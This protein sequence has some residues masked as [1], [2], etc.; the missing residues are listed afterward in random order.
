MVILLEP[1]GITA[2]ILVGYLMI[3]VF[4]DDSNKNQNLQ[5]THSF[6][7]GEYPMQFFFLFLNFFKSNILTEYWDDNCSHNFYLSVSIITNDT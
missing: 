4:F 3:I 5:P 6:M 1:N 2:G 7:G